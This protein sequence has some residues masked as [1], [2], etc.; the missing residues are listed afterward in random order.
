MPEGPETKYLVNWL[1]K[2]LKNKSIK[3]IL[4]HG[5]RY[6]KHGPPKN[7]DKIKFPLKV[8][9]IDCKGKFIYWTF[10]NTDIVLFNTLGMSGWYQYDKDKHNHIEF[11]FSDFSIYFNDYRNFGTLIFC[12]Q[13]NLDK[14]LK[15]LGP[16]ILEEKDNVNDFIKKID[17]KRNDTVIGA[18]IM[19]QKV[20]A[21]VGNYIRAEALYIAKLDPFKKIKD[22]KKDK[23][24]ELWN[25][26]KQVGWLYYNE[27]KGKKLGIIN[28]KYKLYNL[29][30]KSGP[31]K[32]KREQGYFLV[33]QQKE[34]PLG[35]KVI[36]DVINGRTI[37]YVKNIQK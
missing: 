16:D 22:I 11:K 5:G 31:S 21:G 30:K 14:K 8:D 2:D 3:N 24:V 36:T 15:T 27:N 37:H 35:N 7:F 10:K 28:N 25:I 13:D 29:Y 9:K 20:S 4:I 18:A 12:Y 26:L 6:K 1:N 33:Y 17:K 32:Y 34:D 19:D 23:L